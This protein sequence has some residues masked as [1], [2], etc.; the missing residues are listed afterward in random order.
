MDPQHLMPSEAVQNIARAN[1]LTERETDVLHMH[2]GY[3]NV[4]FIHMINPSFLYEICSRRV[5]A[6]HESA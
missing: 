2:E 3:Y 5:D 1:G 6:S 4:F